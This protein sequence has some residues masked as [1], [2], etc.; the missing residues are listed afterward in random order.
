[1][2]KL[3][4]NINDQSEVHLTVWSVSE[5]PPCIYVQ[6]KNAHYMVVDV[7]LKECIISLEILGRISLTLMVR[8]KNT[9]L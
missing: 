1:M 6:R 3:S 8:G 7:H 4:T 5:I 9:I 2:G